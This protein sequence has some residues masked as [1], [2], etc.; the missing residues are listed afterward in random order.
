MVRGHTESHGGTHEGRAD[1]WLVGAVVFLVLG[2]VAGPAEALFVREHTRIAHGAGGLSLVNSGSGLG[3]AIAALGDLDRDGVVDIA[4]SAGGDPGL[5]FP[6][7][8]AIFVLFLR[9]DGSVRATKRITPHTAGLETPHLEGT[10]FG[11]SLACVGD[12]DG[13]GN[14]EL[15]VGNHGPDDRGA[16]HLLFLDQSGGVAHAREISRDDPRFEESLQFGESLEFLGDLDGDGRPE[17]AIGDSNAPRGGTNRG[18][19]WIVELDPQGAVLDVELLAPGEP[20]F[21]APLSDH[22][23]FGTGLANLGDL[24]GDGAIELAVGSAYADE[25]TDN[26]G[27]AWI[28]S[29]DDDFAVRRFRKIP[30][31]HPA[32]LDRVD[33]EDSIGHDLSVVDDLD[34]DG[35][36]ELAVSSASHDGHGYDRGA[37]WIVFLGADGEARQVRKF[38][39]QSGGLTATL[40]D[41]E[42]FGS[43]VESIGDLD[44]DGVSELAVGAP[45]HPSGGQ[46]T[47]SVRVLFLRGASYAPRSTLEATDQETPI[48]TPLVSDPTGPLP[49]A[50]TFRKW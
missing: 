8:G 23:N 45:G 28:V 36:V 42:G 22:Q 6:A 13:D 25:G 41:H 47:G 35:I 11:R 5:G 33:Y 38:G 24:D 19:V 34:G 37:V 46:S 32:F 21:G 30:A 44:G 2:L 20:G 16:V 26:T 18:I 9:P 39:D 7:N 50:R 43:S 40:V 14:P 48:T 10:R 15:A 29:I 12:L 49:Q 4:V 17:L 27:A 3:T 31:T 1:G